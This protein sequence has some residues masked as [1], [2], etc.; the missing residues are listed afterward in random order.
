MSGHKQTYAIDV[1]ADSAAEAIEIAAE[2]LPKGA[3]VSQSEALEH[4]PGVWRVSLRY[5]GGER[6]KGEFPG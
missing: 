3:T 1:A 5:H 4:S 2:A 6:R